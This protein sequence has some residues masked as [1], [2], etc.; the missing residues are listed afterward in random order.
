MHYIV[1]LGNP[2]KEYENTRHN[3]GFLLVQ[4]FIE[5]A[6]LPSLHESGKYGGLVSEG[7]FNGE[8]VAV[9]L[10]QTFMNVSGSAVRK[11]VPDEGVSKLIVIYDDIDL[12]IGEWKLSIGRG[13]GGHNG[14][15]SVI[16]SLG[17]RDFAR[18]RVGVGRKS[19]WTGS[20]MRPKGK[21]LASYL[22]GAFSSKEEKVLQEIKNKVTEILSV[23]IAHGPEKAMNT[24]N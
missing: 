8:E 24:F 9:L 10:P 14:V 18:L 1:G 3:I 6:G 2:G 12:P 11:L 7:V 15:K 20:L 16:E 23:F 19:V 5:E 22:L 13:D 17:S 21:A 4:N